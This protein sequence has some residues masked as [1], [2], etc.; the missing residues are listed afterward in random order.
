[1]MCRFKLLSDEGADVIL[2]VSPTHVLVLC[3]W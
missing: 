2:L 1:M 3:L